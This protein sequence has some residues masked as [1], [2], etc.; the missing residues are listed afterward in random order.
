MREISL[1]SSGPGKRDADLGRVIERI[2]ALRTKTIDQGCSEQEALAAAAKV[3][4]MLERYGLSMSEVEIRAQACEGFGVDTG[5]RKQGPTDH[6]V[7]AIADFCDCRVWSETSLSGTLRFVFFGLP[8]DVEA[9]HYLYDLVAAAFDTE[10]ASFKCGALYS[11][12]VGAEKRSAVNSFQIGLAGGLSGKLKKLKAARN[13]AVLKST[14]RDLVPIKSSIL[15]EEFEKL[16]FSLHAKRVGGRRKVLA[17]AYHAGHV[18]GER[19]E[20]HAAIA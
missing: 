1:Q 20:P 10:T 11:V 8:A 9:A 3:A 6:C 13:A 5:R 4:E 12:M 15:D 18:A 2:R 16:G 7:P 14:G 19:F 17:E